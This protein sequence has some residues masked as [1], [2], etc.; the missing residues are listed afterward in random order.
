[1][2]VAFVNTDDYT[3]GA[4]IAC[5][6][7][8]K[9]LEKENIKI[10]LLTLNS[11]KKLPFI[12]TYNN[13]IFK[14]FK[15]KLFFVLERLYFI[16]FEKNSTVRFAFS[17]AN[18]GIN[19]ELNF[20]LSKYD[21][22]HL[23]WTNFGFISINSLKNIIN[24]QKPLVW[25]L[26]DMW[27]MTGGCH[28]SGDCINFINECGNCDNYLRNPSKTDLSAKVYAKKKL[29][30]EKNNSLKIVGCSEWITQRAKQSSLLRKF[31]CISI[32]NPLDQETFFEIKDINNLKTNFGL[33]ISKKYIIISAMKVSVIWKGFTYF[34]AAMESLKLLVKTQNIEILVLGSANQKDFENI[35]FVCHFLGLL[36]DN[37]I[38]NEYYNCADVLVTSSIQENL[39]NTIMEAMASGTPCVGF[40]IGG[41]PEMITHKETG[42]LAE[43]KSAKDLAKGIYWTL[44]KSDYKNISLNCIQKVRANYSE[45]IIADKY[46]RLYNSIQNNKN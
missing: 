35:P 11:K 27:A 12:K 10:D 4:A 6:R 43:Y 42:Y 31:D 30:I 41:I 15:A 24:S 44:Y 9:A 26:H 32:P 1:M 16:F 17:P 29:A 25:T 8:I 18:I 23:H 46:I 45:K 33:D 3:G 20:D 34:E 5:L 13:S 22:I 40:D 36:S 38:I 7:L 39:P 19:F 2:R 21:I 14:N 37:K 28:H